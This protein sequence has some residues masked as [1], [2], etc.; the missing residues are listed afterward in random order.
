MAHN[1]GTTERAS[2]LLQYWGYLIMEFR[3]S[4]NESKICYPLASYILVVTVP[5]LME[6]SQKTALPEYGTRMGL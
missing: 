4:C 1:R 3:L 5:M 6:S 2:S